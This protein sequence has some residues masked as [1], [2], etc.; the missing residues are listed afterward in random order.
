MA[1]VDEKSYSYFRYVL[2]SIEDFRYK[3]RL[4][5]NGSHRNWVITTDKGFKHLLSC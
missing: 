3:P 1:Q 5:E 2:W 4:F